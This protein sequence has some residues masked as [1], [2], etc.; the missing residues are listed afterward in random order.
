MR[1]DSRAIACVA[2]PA[3]R[4]ATSMPPLRRVERVLDRHR[5]A[6]GW[7]R[8]EFES[9]R[10]QRRARAAS[11][12]PGGRGRGSRSASRRRAGAAIAIGPSLI[13][14]RAQRDRRR[15]VGNGERAFVERG[16]ES[17]R[18]YW[19]RRSGRLGACA[20]ATTR[21]SACRIAAR[22]RTPANSAV[23]PPARPAI[24]AATL[25]PVEAN[26]SR[27]PTRPEKPGRSNRRRLDAQG[28]RERRGLAAAPQRRAAGDGGAGEPHGDVVEIEPA[29]VEPEVG[30]E[31]LRRR[32]RR[33]GRAR[34][35]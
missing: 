8:P 16:R 17:D 31:P 22:Q 28:A 30:R 5:R 18:R 20:A 7:P 32:A 4:P 14:P 11:R 2:S 33:R 12:A 15:P 3:A 21:A 6:W 13:A 23:P 26:S 34:P 19:S 1:S 24:S 35:R 25:R 10:R 27:P 29:L 9:R